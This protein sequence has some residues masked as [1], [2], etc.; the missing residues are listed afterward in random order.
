MVVTP[1]PCSILGLLLP[2]RILYELVEKILG[3]S[4]YVSPEEARSNSAPAEPAPEISEEERSTYLAEIAEIDARSRETG[5]MDATD[6]TR[7]KDLERMLG[8]TVHQE[9]TAQAA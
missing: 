3:E 1:N 8:E 6:T 7:R 2:N 5:V 9:E 4:G